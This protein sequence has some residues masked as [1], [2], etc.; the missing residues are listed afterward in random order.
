[1]DDA[2]RAAAEALYRYQARSEVRDYQ[3]L[4]KTQRQGYEERAKAVIRSFEQVGWRLVPV[5][6][7]LGGIRDRADSEYCAMIRQAQK[8]ECLGWK[9]K[10]NSGEFGEAELDAHKLCGE[11]LGRH[12]GLCQAVRIIQAAPR[13]WDAP[14]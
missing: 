9:A 10:V 11:L 7:V 14:E 6:S 5:E 2:T 13:P 8:P 4:P 12:R 3:R 1:M